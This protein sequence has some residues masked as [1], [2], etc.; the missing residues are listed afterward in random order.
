MSTS[1]RMER[2]FFLRFIALVNEVQGTTVLPSQIKVSKK[3]VWC[4]STKQQK[5]KK[6]A[7]SK[8]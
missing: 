8:V 3:S 5:Q 6:D 7:L 1:D 2:Q 4:K